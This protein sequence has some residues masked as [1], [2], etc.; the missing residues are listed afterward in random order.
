MTAFS[1]IDIEL[2][3]LTK[4]M[5]NES[6]FNFYF[7]FF[8]ILYNLVISANNFKSIHDSKHILLFDLTQAKIIDG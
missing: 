2:H 6:L 8:N 1:C 3:R 5:V 4:C 7:V